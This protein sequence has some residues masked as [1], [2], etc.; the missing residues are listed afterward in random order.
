MGRHKSSSQKVGHRIGPF[1]IRSTLIIVCRKSKKTKSEKRQSRVHDPS[2]AK[3]VLSMFKSKLE[4]TKRAQTFDDKFGDGQKGFQKKSP[5]E[6]AKEKG[7]S[8]IVS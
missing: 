7:R 2:K 3:G 4:D 1:N 6:E 8:F 5:R